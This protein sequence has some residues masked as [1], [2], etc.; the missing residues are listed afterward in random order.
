MNLYERV[1][2]ELNIVYMTDEEV[3]KYIISTHDRQ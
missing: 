2:I 3:I 1:K